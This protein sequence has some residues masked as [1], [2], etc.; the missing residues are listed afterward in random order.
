MNVR[1]IFA[2]QVYICYTH[3]CINATAKTPTIATDGENIDS[4]TV[5]CNFFC[6]SIM[7]C[8]DII[9]LAIR[10]L[11]SKKLTKEFPIPKWEKNQREHNVQCVNFFS[12]NCHYNRIEKQ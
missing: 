11:Y 6:P 1:T 4:R 5:W 7:S 8:V 3:K 9:D 12:S 10:E 2:D